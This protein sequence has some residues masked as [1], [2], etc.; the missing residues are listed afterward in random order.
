MIVLTLV[1]LVL[2]I[3]RYPGVFR[4]VL[5]GSNDK[6]VDGEDADDPT[7]ISK[8]T[9]NWTYAMQS[10]LGGKDEMDGVA[11]DTKGNVVIGGPFEYTVDFNGTKRTAV[12]GIDFYVSKLD[13]EGKELWFISLDSGG[14]DFMWDLETDQNNDILISGGY[15][16]VLT[17]NGKTHNANRD[18]SALYAKI[19]GDTGK[20][21]WF[22]TA[23]V[24]GSG[25]AIINS[26]RT[27]GGN[28]I[29]VD[30]KGNAVAILSAHGEQYRIGNQIFQNAGVM[31]SF[32]VKISPAGEY[33]W[34]YQFLGAGRKQARAIGVNGNDEI[35]FGHQLIGP[36]NTAEGISFGVSNNQNPLGTAGL[37]TPE[38]KLKWMIPIISDGFANVR[39]AG[40]DAEGNVYFTGEITNSTKIGMTTVKGYQNGSTF[41]VKYTSEGLQEW[42][43]VLG[44]NED[45]NGGELIVYADKVAI[46][47]T[48]S[49]SEYNLYDATG[50]VLAK[51]IHDL[52]S[53]GVRATLAVFN[54]LGQLVTTYAPAY[55]DVSSGG[56]LEYAG[57]NC[58]VF[59]H[60]FYGKIEYQNG[61]VY[62]ATNSTN[63]GT[64][65]K[66]IALAKVCI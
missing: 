6:V 47:G 25:D 60:T 18:G 55:T 58:L 66:D 29:K 14:D 30:S 27:A 12:N 49:G 57:N 21:I 17:I 37:L 32:I 31:D 46:S 1:L 36:I 40:G 62:T 42:V 65:D 8:M 33:L 45:D 64:P 5:L 51:N 43:R 61:D 24:I 59:E 26:G 34:A 15:G 3:T 4:N 16:G 22:T 28:E 44:N 23:G 63:T 13:S 50:K 9:T 56:V 48:N 35:A 10:S 11:V 54:T 52:E 53:R 20:F 38:G 19:D 2:A 7:T 39:G 41:L